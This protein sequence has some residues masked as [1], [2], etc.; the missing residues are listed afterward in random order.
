M[1]GHPT[2][3]AYERLTQAFEYFNYFNIALFGGMLSPCR[4]TMR[5]HKG[6]YG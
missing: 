6:A 5:R 1:T 4:I 2:Q 3:R